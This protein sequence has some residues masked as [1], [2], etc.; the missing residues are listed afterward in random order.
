VSASSGTQQL[1]AIAAQV[2]GDPSAIRDIAQSWAQAAASCGTETQTVNQ[3]AATAT[4]GW[5]GLSAA[6]FEYAITQFSAASRNQRECLQAGAKA[7]NDA[8]DALEQAQSSINRITGNL[9]SQI[10]LVNS[11]VATGTTPLIAQPAQAQAI[12][13]ATSQA[14]AVADE[15]GKAMDQA[16]KVLDGVLPR[17]KGSLAFSKL[18]IP[19]AQ[20]FIPQVATPSD[21]GN[22]FGNE[23]IVAMYLVEH[24][25]SK[26]AAAGIAA[27]IAGES[28]G[29]PESVGTGGWGL[30]GWTPQEAGQ[31]Q[32]LY[33]TNNSPADLA[34]QMPAILAY[35]NA[36]GKTNGDIAALNSISDPIQ[37]AKYYS[38]NF[39]R[40]QV[41]DSDV[42]TNVAAAVFNALG[43]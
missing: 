24:G 10:H 26:A 3:A 15:A 27:C 40:P 14:Q 22:N 32:S 5:T 31:Y 8:A 2:S 23:L 21:P 1:A 38:Q 16:S 28:K 30:I 43:G 35:N 37:A 41:T 29:S 13:E 12:A 11:A 9:A 7:L 18:H 33:P 34:R 25:Y 20:G 39:E 6:S 42:R 19:T 36:N 17:M 4:D